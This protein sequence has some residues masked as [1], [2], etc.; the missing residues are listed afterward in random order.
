MEKIGDWTTCY[1][2]RSHWLEEPCGRTAR[3][4]YLDE[5]EGDTLLFVHGPA[6]WSFH[7]REL[8]QAFR[9]RYRTIS[10]DYSGCGLSGMPRPGY[11]YRPEDRIGELIQLIR[12]L[13]LRQI[14][15]IADDTAVVTALGVAVR[16]SRRM[17]R[18]VL[19]EP[20]W[21]SA[22]NGFG[23]MSGPHAP[24]RIRRILERNYPADA[25][26][27]V[28]GGYMEPWN[29]WRRRC[30]LRRELRGWRRAMRERGTLTTLQEKLS[31]FANYPVCL[32]S[33]GAKMNVEF[34][35]VR[36][37]LYII[38]NVMNSVETSPQ[39][40]EPILESFFERNPVF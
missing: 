35:F 10:L 32:V 12:Q 28:R 20:R 4:H 11:R 30:G 8:I 31:I 21:P 14:T 23:L 33:G 2:F 38:Q 3:L 25:P 27:E 37:E 39:R 1:P 19:I 24:C 29:S 34:P 5:G 7:W 13:R 15:L 40:L 17:A 16:T 26:A 36:S 22:E 9:G 6:T 18:F